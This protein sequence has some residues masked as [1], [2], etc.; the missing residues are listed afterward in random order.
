MMRTK[1]DD[2]RL[3]A[4][5]CDSLVPVETVHE[6]PWFSVRNRGGYY[7]IEYNHPQSLI[8]PI[9]DNQFVV[10]ARVKR[11]V[12]ADNTWEL[13]AG[14]AKG[15]ETPVQTA[16]RELSEETGIEIKDINRFKMLPPIAITTRSPCLPYIFQINLSREEYEQRKK[17]DEEIECVGCFHFHDIFQKIA[18][19]GIYIGLHI[20][21]IMRY[22]LLNHGFAGKTNKLQKGM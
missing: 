14:G 22:F 8:L 10:M 2:P 20:A 19:S 21:V 11:P 1:P 9:V 13:P 15:N 6:N 17:H 7:T 16:A 3:I 18:N 5:Q 4:P 12:I